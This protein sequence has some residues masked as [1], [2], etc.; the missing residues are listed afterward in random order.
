MATHQEARRGSA[1]LCDDLFNGLSSKIL[2]LE[3]TPKKGPCAIGPQNERVF[4]Y[5]YHAKRTDEVT[6]W[7]RGDLARLRNL[8]PG[9]VKS[10]GRKSGIWKDFSAT[11][12]IRNPDEIDAAV[13]CLFEE[14]YPPAGGAIITS[15]DLL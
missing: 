15:V 3:R 7:C 1:C 14:A 5:V 2:N 11:F 9:E 10:R 6:I 4:A 8:A 13:R 12:K